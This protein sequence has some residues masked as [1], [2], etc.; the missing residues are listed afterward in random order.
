MTRTY[1]ASVNSYLAQQTHE[2]RLLTDITFSST[3]MRLHS[4]VGSMMVGSTHYDGIGMQG[5]IDKIEED[6][7]TLAPMVRAYFCVSNSVTMAEAMNETLFN[8]Q[9][10]F[11]RAWTLNGTLVNTPEQWFD[12]RIG[13][14]TLKRNDQERGTYLELMVQTR[15]DRKRSQKYYTKEDLAKTYSGDTFFNYLHL[16][17]GQNALWGNKATYFNN[18]VV[19]NRLGAMWDHLTVPLTPPG[20]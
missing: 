12:G 5:G 20:G 3:T 9:V 4:G 2:L 18:R 14:V 13:Q 1:A 19:G 7:S 15:M 10:V 6:P 16:I 8:K 11:R 17:Q